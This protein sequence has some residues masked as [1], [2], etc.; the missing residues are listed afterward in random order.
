MSFAEQFSSFTINVESWAEDKCRGLANA[1]ATRIVA[2]TPVGSEEQ[3]D[4]PGQAKGNWQGTIG[5]PAAGTIDHQDESGAETLAEI[6]SKVQEWKPSTG[7]SFYI[8]N[9]ISYIPILEYGL[10]PNP[11]KRGTGRTVNG[12]ST[13]APSGM[14]GITV[15]EVGGSFNGFTEEPI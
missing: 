14:V 13:Q 10:Y 7:E 4:D 11:P 15:A 9:N 3:V 12:F 6:N 1:V 2:R 5:S 8:T